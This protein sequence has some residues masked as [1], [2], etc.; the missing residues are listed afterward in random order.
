MIDVRRSNERWISFGHT[1]AWGPP[2]PAGVQRV[3]CPSGQWK[4]ECSVALR[5]ADSKGVPVGAFLFVRL[6]CSHSGRGWCFSRSG[7]HRPSILPRCTAG[8]DCG[9]SDAGSWRRRNY[10]SVIG[11][12]C[13]ARPAYRPLS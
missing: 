11:A 8:Y 1:S 10:G 13:D 2:N 7:K 9:Q 4:R 6:R 3:Q 12:G 5:L